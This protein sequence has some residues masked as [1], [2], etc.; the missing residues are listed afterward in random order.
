[1]PVRVFLFYEDYLPGALPVFELFFSGDC[2]LYIWRFFKVDQDMNPILFCKTFYGLAFVFAYSSGQ[3]V[4][5]TDV[6]CAVLFAG[7]D[8]DVVC[9]HL[10]FWIP[11]RGPE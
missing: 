3:V 4:G 7:Q 1:M 8:V 5:D 11:A 10:F 9:L 6:E 2:R